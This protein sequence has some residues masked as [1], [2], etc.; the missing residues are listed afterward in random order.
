MSS[1]FEIDDSRK[2]L[3]DTKYS[4]VI[5]IFNKLKIPFL[6]IL[7]LGSWIALGILQSHVSNNSAKVDELESKLAFALN[8]GSGKV[9]EQ[10]IARSVS[11]INASLDNVAKVKKLESAMKN[12]TEKVSTYERQLT[13]TETKMKKMESAMETITGKVSKLE[14]AGKMYQKEL[15]FHS[16][17]ASAKDCQELQRHGFSTSGDFLIDPDGRYSGKRAFKVYCDFQNKLTKV[18]PMIGKSEKQRQVFVYDSQTISLIEAS[19]IC[20]QQISL[21]T[22]KCLNG[23]W[24]KDVQGNTHSF[25]EIEDFKVRKTVRIQSVFLPILA[26]GYV[27]SS[28]SDD[29]NVNEVSVGD[30]IC[31]D[32][33]DAFN[34]TIPGS[35]NPGSKI[36]RHLKNWGETFDI[37]FDIILRSKRNAHTCTRILEVVPYSDKQESFEN[38]PCIYLCK[39]DKL[40]FEFSRENSSASS[41]YVHSSHMLTPN[42]SHHVQFRQI[43]LH[44]YNDELKRFVKIDNEIVQERDIK[45]FVSK[46]GILYVHAIDPYGT[47]SNFTF[48]K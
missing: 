1:F 43:R 40:A 48:R 26:I 35:L 18:S 7:I 12:V 11:A 22:K 21:T 2:M 38:E 6:L 37:Q 31:S 23:Y 15:A 42:V 25:R 14:T 46:D 30:L 47:I 19:G 29:C 20:Y 27:D 9:S 41:E 10:E 8:N 5:G 36:K 16:R 28:S 39:N 32:I 4:R 45:E 24:Y 34:F 33:L 17:A 13:N 44:G 3:Q